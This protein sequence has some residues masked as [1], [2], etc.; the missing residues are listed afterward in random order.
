MVKSKIPQVLPFVK[1]GLSMVNNPYAQAGIKLHWELS[2]MECQEEQKKNR[3]SLGI[4][5]YIE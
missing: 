5:I 3:E 4:K 1:Q 2:G